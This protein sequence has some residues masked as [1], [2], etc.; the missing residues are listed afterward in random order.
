MA[1]T[2][3]MKYDAAKYLDSD[4]MIAAYLSEAFADGDPV[5]VGKALGD[6]ARAKG[7]SNVAK[8]TGLGRESLYK[9]LSGDVS[10]S[11]DTVQKVID[12]FG[13]RLVVEPEVRTS[14]QKGYGRLS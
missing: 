3:T 6:V 4:E 5:L 2:K 9:S 1:K 13:F 8:A 14:G 10:P 7:M 12:S 11:F